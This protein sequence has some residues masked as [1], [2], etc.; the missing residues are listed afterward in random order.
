[1]QNY[2]TAPYE[3]FNAAASLMFKSM[4]AAPKLSRAAFAQ[5][6]AAQ[7]YWSGIF[8]Y[9]TTFMMPTTNALSSFANAEKKNSPRARPLI[10]SETIVN[11]LT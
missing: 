9:T 1:M 3:I 11:C 2:F 8:R 6:R 4:R 10:T 5:S 7:Y